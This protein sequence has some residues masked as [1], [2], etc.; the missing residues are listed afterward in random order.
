MP[1]MG[2]ANRRDPGR[3]ARCRK[4]V[5]NGGADLAAQDRRLARTMMARDEQDEAI[6]GI[7][8]AFQGDIDGPPGAVETVTVEVDDP[9]GLERAGAELP[10]P[11]PV[12]RRSGTNGS[13]QFLPGTGRG[14]ARGNASGGGVDCSVIRC[15]VATSPFWG[16]FR[17][18]ARQGADG[19]RYPSPELGFVRAE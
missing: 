11:R 4:P 12:E 9:V 17:W 10:V 19:R 8:C 3:V 6:P 16:G 1:R 5:V 18:L 2:S 14:T 13:P 15:A 7:A